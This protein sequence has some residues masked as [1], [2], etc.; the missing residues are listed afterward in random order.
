MSAPSYDLKI[1][2]TAEGAEAWISGMLDESTDLSPLA[3]VKGKIVVDLS[4]VLLVNSLGLRTWIQ[5]LRAARGK[6]QVILRGCSE[7]VVGLLNMVTN[8]AEGAT[9]E[10]FYAP[11]ECESCG[12]ERSVLID[13]QRDLGQGDQPEFPPLP[14]PKCGGKCKLTD[15]PERYLLFLG[16]G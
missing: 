4:K 5:F 15:S 7:P 1:E 14:C 10:S 13:V 2:K 16:D 12:D 3:A 9:V 6:A 8:A 11:F